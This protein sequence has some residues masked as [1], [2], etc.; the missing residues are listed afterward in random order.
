M[1]SKYT[2]IIRKSNLSYLAI[3]LELNISS[4]GDT[5]AEVE[6]NLKDSI[7]LYLEDIKNYP[8]T[9][10]EPISIK[11]LTEFLNDTEPEWYSSDSDIKQ[12][13]K[14]F[15]VNEVAI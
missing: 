15:E 7:E 8:E 11:E 12:L 14:P 13:F 9:I 4:C 3:C 5:L 6:K 1:N 2:A 10:V